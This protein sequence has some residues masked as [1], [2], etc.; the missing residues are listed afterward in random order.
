MQN[1]T[2]TPGDAEYSDVAWLLEELF[3]LSRRISPTSAY[4][5]TVYSALA[6]LS[7]HGDARLTELAAYEGVSQPTMTQA[8][9]RLK[10]DGL[11]QQI[12]DP[13][14]GRA[15]LIS[16]TEAGR[17]ALAERRST[18]GERVAGLLAQLDPADQQA[19]VAATG[20]LRKLAEA[21]PDRR[22][23]AQGNQPTT[24]LKWE[25]Q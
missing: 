11:V 23:G 14:D 25:R 19:I 8:V 16:I 12:P 4:S 20:P 1:P 24:P 9:G 5:L 13:R 10:R 22:T 7:R 15:V 6:S 18:R 17:A 2:G 21:V 3:R